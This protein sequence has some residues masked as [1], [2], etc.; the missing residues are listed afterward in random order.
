MKRFTGFIGLVAAAIVWLAAGVAPAGAQQFTVLHSFASTD[1]AP[2]GAGLI[3][4]PDG[5]LY[6][7]GGVY[8]GTVYRL[9]PDGTNFELLHAFSGSVDGFRPE[10]GVILGLDGNLYGTTY[11]GGTYGVGTVY[12]LSPDGTNF[13]VLHAFSGSG[14]YLP[15]A[16]LLQVPDGTLYGMTQL[17]GQGR[18]TIYRL[19]P[20]GTNFAVLHSFTDLDGYTPFSQASLILGLDGYLYG[21]ALWGGLGYGTVYRLSQDGSNFEVLHSFTGSDGQAPFGLIQGRDGNLYGVTLAG[22]PQDG[23]TIFRLSPDGTNFQVLRSFCPNCR[24][25]ASSPWDPW[26]PYR[27]SLLQGTD[28]ALYGATE[29]GGVWNR[30]TVY[31]LAPD[32]TNFEVLHSF[33]GSP[34]G[35]YALG[36]IQ[37]RDGKLYGTTY[38]GGA[39]NLGTVYR[40]TLPEVEVAAFLHGS[41]G[42]GNPPNLFLDGTQPTSATTKYKD[43]SSVT[44]GGGNSW[45]EVGTWSSEPAF[46]SG[47]VKHLS[48]VRTWIGL[49]NSDDQGTQFD[50]RAELYQNSALIASGEARCISGVTRNP[51]LAK[52]VSIPF[53][54]ATSST[55]DGTDVLILRILTRIGTNSDGTKCA[56][57]SNAVGLRFYFDSATRPSGLTLSVGP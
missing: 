35:Q 36:L 49:K 10:T 26:F 40:L 54:G 11:G 43:S 25:D 20:D 1:G 17:G 38:S 3:Q 45:K 34:D 28:G 13:E 42:T 27:D 30:G 31:R 19:A 7:T 29:F 48:P 52:G 15:S 21:T 46:I 47:V 51:S 39:Q 32:G 4:G 18:S 9:A 57:H 16:G 37:G 44:F 5:T 41:G 23:G 55:F 14:A 6:G 56:G 12:R 2:T 22:G 24:D 8:P 53:S 33:S 50:L